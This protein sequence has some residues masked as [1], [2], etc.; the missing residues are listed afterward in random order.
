MCNL[1]LRCGI[2]WSAIVDHVPSPSAL[3]IA[4]RFNERLLSGKEVVV[5]LLSGTFWA[6]SLAFRFGLLCLGERLCQ[7]S[8]D[9]GTSSRGSVVNVLD[10]V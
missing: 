1:Q 8:L 3:L 5:I 9:S 4:A 7:P 6:D 2:V 10:P